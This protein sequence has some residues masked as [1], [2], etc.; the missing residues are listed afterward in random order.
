MSSSLRCCDDRLNSPSIRD[1]FR[2]ALE[3]HKIQCSMSARG[4]CYDNAVVESFF[5]LLKR[6]RVNRTHYLTRDEAKA[7]SHPELWTNAM[8]FLNLIERFYRYCE[9]QNRTVTAT[10]RQNDLSMAAAVLRHGGIGCPRAE[11]ITR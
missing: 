6:E 7:G 5:G 2:D 1:D 11:A 9:K 10:A 8:I 3:E 4:N